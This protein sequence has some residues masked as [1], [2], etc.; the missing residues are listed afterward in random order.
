MDCPLET[1]NHIRHC[2]EGD[3]KEMGLIGLF[4]IR[5]LNMSYVQGKLKIIFKSHV[6]YVAPV[7]TYLEF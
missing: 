4:V 2:Q 5:I 7:P 3:V 1:R 6:L